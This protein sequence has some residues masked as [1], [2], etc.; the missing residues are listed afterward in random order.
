[1]SARALR[2]TAQPFEMGEAEEETGGIGMGGGWGDFAQ[3]VGEWPKGMG[4]ESDPE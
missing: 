3:P 2:K 4:G 1:M